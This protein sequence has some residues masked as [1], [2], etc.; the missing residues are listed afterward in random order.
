MDESDRRQK[1]RLPG[2]GWGGGKVNED[3]FELLPLFYKMIYCELFTESPHDA[4]IKPIRRLRVHIRKIIILS[5]NQKNEVGRLKK[6]L[7]ETVLF[8]HP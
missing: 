2:V 5:L 7:N 6:R 8:D 1:S 4:T 3:Q